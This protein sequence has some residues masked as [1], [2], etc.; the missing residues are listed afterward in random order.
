MKNLAKAGW[1]RIVNVDESGYKLMEGTG[2][3]EC[4]CGAWLLWM[5]G[6]PDGSC[7]GGAGLASAQKK[8]G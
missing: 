2:V 4:D 5:T 7:Y 1:Y 3:D 8:A 6:Q